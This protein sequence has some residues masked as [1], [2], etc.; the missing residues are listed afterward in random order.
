LK[1]ISLSADFWIALIKTLTIK[2]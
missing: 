1:L 2:V